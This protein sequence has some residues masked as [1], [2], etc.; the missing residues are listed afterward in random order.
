MAEVAV[1]DIGSGLSGTAA[2]R[3]FEAFFTT[4]AHGL[5]MGLAISRSIIEAHHGRIWIDPPV[6]DVRGTT[7]RFALPLHQP[8]RS[9]R[10]KRPSGAG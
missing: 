8:E 9:S 1:R 5:G 6:G 4:K 2:K 3:S 10:A 7:V